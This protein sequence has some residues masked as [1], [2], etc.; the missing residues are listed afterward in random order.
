MASLSSI[1]GS[2]EDYRDNGGVVNDNCNNPQ[3][4]LFNYTR[5]YFNVHS[6][7]RHESSLIYRSEWIGQQ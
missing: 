4:L 2:L 6:E 3:S 1:M 5:C 7:S